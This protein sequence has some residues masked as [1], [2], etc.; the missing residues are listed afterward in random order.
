MSENNEISLNHRDPLRIHPSSTF[1]HV[2]PSP[3][4][5]PSSAPLHAPRTHRDGEETRACTFHRINFVRAL[6]R[7]LSSHRR[8]EVTRDF[9]LSNSPL[10]CCQ[11]YL[12][13]NEEYKNWNI[14]ESC[15]VSF[16]KRDIWELM[17]L[18]ILSDYLSKRIRELI[19]FAMLPRSSDI[20]FEKRGIRELKYLWIL[21][22]CCQTY[23][24]KN[25]EYENWCIFETES[26]CV[27]VYLSKSETYENWCIFESC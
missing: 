22:I 24:S 19:Y 7:S 18:W 10:T 5:L 12:S 8:N 4:S 3:S 26:C 14:F 1:H 20:S 17:Y 6:F 23:L 13:K 9:H 11:T 25:E 16:E 15:C 27:A 21:L 2:S